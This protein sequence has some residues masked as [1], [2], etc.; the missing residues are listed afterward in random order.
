M[1]DTLETILSGPSIIRERWLSTEMAVQEVVAFER[2]FGPKHL[3]LACHAALPLIITPELLNLLHLN[4]LDKEKIP[5]IAE[6]DFLLSP[7]CR[8]IDEGLYEVEPGVREVLLVELEN[9]FGW[10]RP[11]ELANFLLAYLAKK[12]DRRQQP[13][14]TR[15]HQWIAQAYIDPDQVIGEMNAFLEESLSLESQSVINLSS[16]I[17]LA[18]MLEVAAEPL[19]RANL[20]TEYEQL[21]ND[22]RVLAGLLYGD[23]QALKQ[24]IS[25]KETIEETSRHH[26]QVSSSLVNYITTANKSLVEISDEDD[27]SSQEQQLPTYYQD[28]HIENIHTLLFEGFTSED[29]L[30]FCNDQPELK[31][32]YNQIVGERQK[33]TIVDLLLQ[34]LVQ[35]MAFD[36]F[37][38][39]AEKSKP[40][41]YTQYGPY[42]VPLPPTNELHSYLHRIRVRHNTFD[43][44]VFQ[45]GQ[46]RDLSSVSLEQFYIPLRL[47]KQLTSI[48]PDRIEQTSFR[49]NEFFSP[50]NQLGRYVTILGDAGSGKTTILNYLTI[51]LAS[52]R[53]ENNL[54]LVRQRIGF[55]AQSADDL[56]IPLYISLRHYWHFCKTSDQSITFSSFVEFLPQYF[57]LRYGGL[58]FI[59]GF[60]QHLLDSGR[61][62]L[63]LDGLDEIPDMVSRAETTEFIYSLVNTPNIKRNY[64]I[65][66]SRVLAYNKSTRLSSVLQTLLV[67]NLDAE[68]RIVQIKTWIKGISYLTTRRLSAD[69]LIR[70]IS[71]N[72]SLDKLATNPLIVTA[73]CIVYF[74]DHQIPEQRAQL[75]RRCIDIMLYERMRPDEPGQFLASFAGRPEFKRQLLARLAF[76]ML[77]SK[78]NEVSREQA[79]R[80]LMDGFRNVTESE[81]LSTSYDFLDTIT[82]RGTLLQEREGFFAFTQRVFQEFLAG[83]HLILGLRPRTRYK[84]W[85]ELLQDDHWREPIRLAVGTTVF[86]NTLTCEDFLSELLNFTNESDAKSVT[87]LTGYTLAAQALWDLGRRGQALLENEL[88][89]E[90]ITGLAIHL[91]A[92]TIND[93]IAN[94]L[95]ERVATA[96]ILGYLGDPREGV[97]TLPP[98]LTSI[99]QGKFLYG[100]KKERREISQFQAGVYPVTNA[101][102]AKFIAVGGYENHSWWSESGWRWQQSQLEENESITDLLKTRRTFLD[103]PNLIKQSLEQG[104]MSPEI[105]DMWRHLISITE[106]EAQHEL[107]QSLPESSHEK[108]LYWNNPAYNIPNQPVVG[109]NWYEAEAFCNWLT[110][111]YKRTYRLPTE[112]EWERLARGQHNR[113]Y[114]W[115]NSWQEGITNT[116]ESGINQTSVVGIFPNS[117]S[118]TGSQDCAGN[119]WEW[120]M[121]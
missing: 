61:C 73:L 14:I 113:E 103:N 25:Q 104:R 78:K 50:K 96:Q 53:L 37:L 102:F 98:L 19:E 18:T 94:L 43:L 76:E 7:L 107:I 105:A 26:K 79:A 10:Q 36:Y 35:K 12:P 55:F 72:D 58:D 33:A 13:D 99:I 15:T 93:P 101:Q 32:V 80:W 8:P 22:T 121:D 119:V 4:F 46:E 42:Y 6:T 29:L 65:L 30:Q 17:Q 38:S 2:R 118:P 39:W 23:K 82:V 45:E 28:Y 89:N 63:I 117:I 56:P 48:N 112:E 3:W 81:R 100:E 31:A 97:T 84:L 52:A 66:S 92:P 62:L 111:T 74:Y 85:P 59:K 1:A 64:I 51:T 49:S 27:K 83:Y 40:A 16:Q 106:E 11:L 95:T 86:E 87:R 88:Q 114:P 60:F 116:K 70:A 41:H 109:V 20:Q 110:A 24:S 21:V 34:H 9:R 44:S 77:L 67:Q 120:C 75:Y 57:S 47:V 68:E 69:E 90:I 71:I 5:W 108:P 115:G 54:D 91:T